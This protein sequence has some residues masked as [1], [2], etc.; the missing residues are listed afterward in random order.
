M[1]HPN[2]TL[3]R[4]GYEA[5]EKGDLDTLRGLFTDDIVWHSPG[6]GLLA[7][8]YRGIDQVFG[9]FGKV[10]ELSG[11]T[12]RSDIHDVLANDEHAVALITARGEREGKTLDSLQS[13][14]FHVTDGKVTE[15]WLEALDLYANDEFWS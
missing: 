1:A 8:E 5:F 10:M 3:L 15:V 12:Y 9:L 4:N 13:H 11:G 2:E 14:V 6:K 7:G